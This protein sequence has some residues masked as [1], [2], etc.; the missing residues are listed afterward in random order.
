MGDHVT[1]DEAAAFA[2]ALLSAGARVGVRDDILKSTS[3]GWACRW[4]REKV[5][6]LMLDGGADPRE[7][8]AE[9]WARPRAWAKKM[10]H[11]GI[12]KLLLDYGAQVP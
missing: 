2:A 5:A 9:P 7:A 11:G 4:G 8:D 12:D 3:L 1:E 6:K 10:G